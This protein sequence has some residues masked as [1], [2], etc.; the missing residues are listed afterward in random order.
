MNGIFVITPIEWQYLY[1]RRIH[2]L[3]NDDF[4]SFY[5]CGLRVSRVL[6]RV[7]ITL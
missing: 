3:T 4:R 7:S 6:D 1:I 2:S 5:E